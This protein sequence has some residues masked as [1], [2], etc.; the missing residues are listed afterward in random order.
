MAK[1]EERSI[2]TLL[3]P[4]LPEDSDL[5]A[6]LE[7]GQRLTGRVWENGSGKLLRGVISVLALAATQR[8]QTWT[9]NSL[10]GYNLVGL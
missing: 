9:I 8:G 10:L 2:S 4:G 3:H 7:V 1:Q 6:G 5:W